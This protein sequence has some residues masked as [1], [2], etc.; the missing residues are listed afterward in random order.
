MPFRRDYIFVMISS[1]FQILII[2][3]IYHFSFAWQQQPPS[4]SSSIDTSPRGRRSFFT[5][6]SSTAAGALL[7]SSVL[8]PLFAPEI[9]HANTEEE[10]VIDVYFGCGCVRFE[11]FL[12][13]APC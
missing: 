7:G 13:L 10:D 5:E 4:I 6:C 9:V 3:S 12:V 1:I 2:F 11:S 8:G